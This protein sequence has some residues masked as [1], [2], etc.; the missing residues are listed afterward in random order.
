[1]NILRITAK[2]NPLK[3]EELKQALKSSLEKTLKFQGAKTCCC[4]NIFEENIFHI[5]QE[6][7]DDQ[8]LETYLE[9]KEY[10]FLMGAITVLGEL[11]DQKIYKTNS[12]NQIE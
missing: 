4:K 11:K 7:N 6:W 2:A 10:Q 1:M 5:E 9:S 12:V 3:E 8:K